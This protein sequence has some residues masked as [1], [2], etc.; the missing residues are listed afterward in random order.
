MATHSH[1]LAWRIPWTEEPARLQSMG[2]QIVRYDWVTNTF[3]FNI[4]TTADSLLLTWQRREGNPLKSLLTRALILECLSRP[5]LIPDTEGRE[6]ERS[7][8]KC[9]YFNCYLQLVLCCDIWFKTRFRK[10]ARP[11]AVSVW[12]ASQWLRGKESACQCRRCRGCGF[13]PRA[14]KIPWRRWSRPSPAFLPGES[15]GQRSLEGCSPWGLMTQTWLSEHAQSH[16]EA[17]T[18]MTWSLS[19]AA[20]VKASHW[21]L[22]FWHA[23]SGGHWHSVHSNTHIFNFLQNCQTVPYTSLCSQEW[24]SDCVP[25]S[26]ALGSASSSYRHPLNGCVVVSYYRLICISLIT[27]DI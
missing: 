15:H 13:D 5:S 8:L 17:S 4:Q 6:R 12:R 24:R 20:S 14:G 10:E 19:K 27:H 7:L 23:R 9:S 2:S 25:S 22:L 3:T 26:P 1:I 18:F 21:G 16:Q 11:L